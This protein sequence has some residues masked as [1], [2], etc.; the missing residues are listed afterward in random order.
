MH[1]SPRRAAQATTVINPPPRNSRTLAT[2]TP[3]VT[4]P[5]GYPSAK[6]FSA[7]TCRTPFASFCRRLI[8][9]TTVFSS[10]VLKQ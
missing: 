2:V 3:S 10:V 6:L 5:R 9:I 4:E 1:V 7:T 8:C